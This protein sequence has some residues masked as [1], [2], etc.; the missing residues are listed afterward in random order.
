[1]NNKSKI[2]GIEIGRWSKLKLAQIIFTQQQKLDAYTYLYTNSV[3][4][5]KKNLEY[6]KKLIRHGHIAEPEIRELD[7]K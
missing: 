1:M 4:I 3:R 5:N 6:F 2:N 7:D